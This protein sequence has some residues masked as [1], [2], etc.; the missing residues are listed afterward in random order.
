M[1]KQDQDDYD[2]G[3]LS[4]SKGLKKDAC[5]FKEHKNNKGKTRWRRRNAWLAGWHDKDIEFI[6]TGENYE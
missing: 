2:N 3:Y 5:P 6:A 4:R 1:N